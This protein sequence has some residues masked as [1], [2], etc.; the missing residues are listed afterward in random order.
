[1]LE[2]EC[3]AIPEGKDYFW[4]YYEERYYEYV[5]HYLFDDE[6]EDW[7]AAMFFSDEVFDPDNYNEK[8]F[9]RESKIVF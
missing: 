5:D 8:S 9:K 2:K 1:M 4:D 7:E 3:G 6:D